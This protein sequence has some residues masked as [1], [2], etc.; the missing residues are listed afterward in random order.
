MTL[1]KAYD[2]F[3][4]FRTTY[5]VEP[6][7]RNYQFTLSYFFDFCIAELGRPLEEIKML[8]VDIHLLNHYSIYL[9]DKPK[10]NQGEKITER[11]RKDYLKSVS[12]FFTFLYDHDYLQSNPC[13]KLRY[14]KV[15]Q[16]AIVPLMEDEVATLLSCYD[17]KSFYGSRNIAIIRCMLDEG[18]RAGEVKR[19]KIDHV[20]LHEGYIE[21]WNSKGKKSRVLPL[22]PQLKS[23]LKN[24]L[25][26]RPKGSD[27]MFVSSAGREFSDWTIRLI[28]DRLKA[29]SGIERIYSHLFRHTFA[30]SYILGGGSVELLR[31]Y[32]GHS[33][34]ST[35]Q[36]YMHVCENLRFIEHIYRIDKCF[37][38]RFY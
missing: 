34:I 27:Y 8:E 36:K 23:A 37:K 9:K 6:T 25:K 7:L 10:N 24:Y 28:V 14:P 30:S 18:M 29:A 4:E 3:M 22:A 21:I 33:D 20:N 5:C 1:K 13:D 17:P 38:K 26:Y 35:T 32:M 15:E 12:T 11:T 2:L 16:P 31:I 19:L